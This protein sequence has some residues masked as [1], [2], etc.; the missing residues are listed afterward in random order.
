MPEATESV[1]AELGFGLLQ[2]GPL[3]NLVL[4]SLSVHSVL[5]LTFF[6]F[7]VIG[8]IQ[9]Q[10]RRLYPIFGSLIQMKLV[11]KKNKTKNPNIF[12]RH[13]TTRSLSVSGTPLPLLFACEDH[14][15]RADFWLWL[16]LFCAKALILKIIDLSQQSGCCVCRASHL[17]T[18]SG[19]HL[20]HRLQSTWIWNVYFLAGFYFLPTI[21]GTLA[22]VDAL[23]TCLISFLKI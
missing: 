8:T 20:E 10:Y 14:F 1:L 5:S 18:S 7:S 16:L 21:K 19:K 4:V 3:P 12:R 6:S 17:F 15:F 13:L 9:F 11:R 23:I 2:W 22:E